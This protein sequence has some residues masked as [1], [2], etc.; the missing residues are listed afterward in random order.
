MLVILIA[1]G[2]L[3][4]DHEVVELGERSVVGAGTGH[5]DDAFLE[6]NDLAGGDNGHAAQDMSLAAAD[7][8]NL[9]D[10][11]GEHTAGALYLDPGFDHVL[12]GGDTDALA[13]LGNVEAEVLD[14]GLHVVI[15]VHE[16]LDSVRFDKQGAVFYLAFL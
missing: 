7:G 15:F 10:D 12:D 9:G 11:A 8:V 2:R 1:L 16:C 6:A 13:R 3:G 5:V 4:H 14:P